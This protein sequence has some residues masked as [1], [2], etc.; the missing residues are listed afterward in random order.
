MAAPKSATF[1]DEAI[2]AGQKVRATLAKALGDFDAYFNALSQLQ[3]KAQTVNA[4]VRSP[5][6][7]DASSEAHSSTGGEAGLRATSAVPPLPASKEHLLTEIALLN[8]TPAPKARGKA[9]AK[10]AKPEAAKKTTKEL[11][12][13]LN[14]DLDAEE[15]VVDP[16]FGCAYVADKGRTTC[17]VLEIETVG[18]VGITGRGT[19]KIPL[20][21]AH[22]ADENYGI[23]ISKFIDL[24]K[25]IVVKPSAKGA[26]ALVPKVTGR[27]LLTSGSALAGI[28]TKPISALVAPPAPSPASSVGADIARLAKERAAPAEDPSPKSEDEQCEIDY[29]VIDGEKLVVGV[30]VNGETIPIADVAGDARFDQGLLDMIKDAVEPGAAYDAAHFVKPSKLVKG[31]KLLPKSA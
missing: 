22:A 3:A 14:A 12:E 17:G 26:R 13:L 18:D 8:A 1:L 27:G 6:A 15:T 5:R 10:G 7:D 28:M 19:F 2:L 24:P 4:M 9:P 11:R 21:A 31:F 23:L 25:P 29:A 30:K 20:C 16:A